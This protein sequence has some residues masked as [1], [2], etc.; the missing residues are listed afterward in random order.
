VVENYSICGGFVARCR[1][2]RLL[3]MWFVDSLPHRI[4]LPCLRVLCRMCVLVSDRVEKNEL[5]GE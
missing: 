2:H 1:L 4:A 3:I 5:V